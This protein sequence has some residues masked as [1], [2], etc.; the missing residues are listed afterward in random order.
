MASGSPSDTLKK[1]CC[2]KDA[3]SRRTTGNQRTGNPISAHPIPLTKHYRASST[4]VVALVIAGFLCVCAEAETISYSDSVALAQADW[5]TSISVPKF[6]SS[7]GVLK[8][9]TCRLNGHVEG[10]TQLENR[11]SEPA[12][13]MMDFCATV[14]L[15]RPDSS[16]I[17]TAIPSVAISHLAGAFDGTLDFAGDSG[18][19]YSG[20]ASDLTEAATSSALSDLALFTG[21]GDIALPITADAATTGSGAGNLTLHFAVSASA[22]LE[23]I[24]DYAAFS[25]EPGALAM[26]LLGI[27]AIIRRSGRQR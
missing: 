11:D 15:L 19:T 1:S 16:L 8:S 21:S 12:T 2:R 5:T 26:M 7:L 20:L 13:V 23:V 27:P 17:V 6:D 3:S 4:A 22:G 14:K 9:V 24:Y 18:A 25:P 10:I